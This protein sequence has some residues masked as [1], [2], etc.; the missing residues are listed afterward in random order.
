MCVALAALEATVRVTGKDGDRAIPFAEFHRLPGDAP[1]TDTNMRADEI[2]TAVD[3]PAKGF[4]ENHTYLKVRDRASYAFALVS[5][6]A[7]L[8]MDGSVIKEARLA[9]G[10]VAHKPWRDTEAEAMLKGKEAAEENFQKAAEAILRDAKGF[11]YNDFK[12]E[13]AKRAVVRA[14]RQ[15]SEMGEKGRKYDDKLH[16]TADQPR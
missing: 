1:Q 15:S 2:I 16:R 10:G 14:L 7:A 9:L 12:I 11:G 4:A 13:L 5:V 8:E 6:A 3:L